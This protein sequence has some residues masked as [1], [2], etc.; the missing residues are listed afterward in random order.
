MVNH[1]SLQVIERNRLF[2]RWCD[3]TDESSWASLQISEKL[4]VIR[5]VT[6]RWRARTHFYCIYSTE[7]R[8]FCDVIRTSWTTEVVSATVGWVCWRVKISGEEEFELQWSCCFI[9]RSRW[10]SPWQ[11]KKQFPPTLG[12]AFFFYALTWRQPSASTDKAAH[13]LTRWGHKFRHS[14]QTQTFFYDH[15]SLEHSQKNNEDWI[16]VWLQLGCIHV[17]QHVGVPTVR[18]DYHLY[19]SQPC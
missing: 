2:C 10:L 11:R 5:G 3:A 19:V 17:L 16:N 12:I 14:Y 4:K 7:N 13:A 1:L 8:S 6:H 15:K 9:R 18:D